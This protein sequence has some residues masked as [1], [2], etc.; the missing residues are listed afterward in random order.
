MYEF[1]IVKLL[2]GCFSTI[3]GDRGRFETKSL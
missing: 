2:K 3:M 1:N